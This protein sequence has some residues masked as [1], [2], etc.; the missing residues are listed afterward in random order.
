MKNYTVQTGDTL[1]GIAAREYGDGELYPVI[2]RM[3][4]LANPDL[5]LV[6]QELL[7]PYVTYRHLWTTDDTSAARAQITQHYYGTQDTKIQLIWEVAS[8]VAQLPIEQGAWLLIPELG[9]VGHYTVVDNDS[10]ASLA[11]DWYGDDHLAIVIAHA[12]EMDP[13]TQPTPGTVLIRPGLNFRL[14]VAGPHPGVGLSLGVR[15]L[16]SHPHL[17]GGGRGGELHQQAAQVVLQ[18]DAVFPSLVGNVTGPAVSWL[19]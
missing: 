3:N 13:D 19:C 14:H 7:V 2:A 9:N 1:F 16:R 18:P 11:A 8:G 5:I 15:R 4:N 12:N 10:F 17:D 6:G